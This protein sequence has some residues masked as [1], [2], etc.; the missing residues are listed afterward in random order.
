MPFLYLYVSGKMRAVGCNGNNSTL[1]NVCGC[2]DYLNGFVSA[3]VH[4]TYNESFGVRV[5]ADFEYFAA[6]N[7]GNVAADSLISFYL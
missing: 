7:A 1:E 3:D 6:D 4:L 2:R 5:T